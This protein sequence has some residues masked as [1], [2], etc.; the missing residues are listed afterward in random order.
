MGLAE[1][2]FIFPTAA[3]IVLCFVFVD[4]KVLIT[5]QCF[6]CFGAVLTASRLSVSNDGIMEWVGRV[7]VTEQHR[8]A[9]W[10]V[11]GHHLLMGSRK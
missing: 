10:K 9:S 8:P 1:V 7:S 5:E 6:G 11:V 4:R 2:D 3:L